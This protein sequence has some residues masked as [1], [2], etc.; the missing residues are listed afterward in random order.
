M[1]SFDESNVVAYEWFQK[2][3]A[4]G[5]SVALYNLAQMNRDG[6]GTYRSEQK[7]LDLFK[8]AAELGHSQA[9][10][11]LAFAYLEGKGVV[12]DYVEAR[13]WLITAAN[14]DESGPWSD[15][16]KLRNALG[17]L[18]EFGHGVEKDAVLAY[19]WYNLAAAG[20]YDKA[21]QNLARVERALSP[22][23]LGEAQRLS[24]EW[25][26]GL[27]IDTRAVSG[28][29]TTQSRSGS[30]N[31]G[32]KL[33]S[34][35]SG[36]LVS[37][38]GHILTNNHVV[39]RC[40]EIR[41]PVHSETATR[42]VSDKTNDLAVLRANLPNKSA[43]IFQDAE[44]VKQGEGISVFGFPLDGYLPAAGNFTVG[45]VS[46]LAGPGNNA[47]LVQI[48]APVQPGNSGGPMLNR[49]G[50]IVG[51][52]VG[53][54]DAIRIASATG[55]IP[56]N[57]N[58]AIS[59]ATIRSFLTGNRIPFQSKSDRFARSRDQVELAEIARTSTVKIE[60]WR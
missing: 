36:F 16:P 44:G 50:H 8:Q 45:I 22:E 52:I 30:R 28:T 13:K 47:S 1:L 41:I 34:V 57:I 29:S 42:V 20:G 33:A 7:A 56:Q 6:V 54:A 59:L 24:R 9:A 3:A 40:T 43:L 11:E 38:D 23:S 39:E 12:R 32:L 55:D 15:V 4:Q 10:G 25:R 18:Y 17:V 2:G 27:D 49:H 21:K 26:P 53:K 46:A 35:G 48:T 60:C 31:S 14:A 51:V 58:F 37:Q 5:D 19:A